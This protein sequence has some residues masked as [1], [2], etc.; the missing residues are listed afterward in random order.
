MSTDDLTLKLR[1]NMGYLL[2]NRGGITCSGGEPLVQAPFVRDLFRQT[3]AL[4]LTTC[5]DTSGMGQKDH[6][7]EVLAETDYVMLCTKSL[8]PD[9]HKAISGASIRHLLTFVDALDKAKVPFRVR[10][11]LIPEGPLCT[12]TP[13]EL[14]RVLDFVNAREHCIG[15][16]LLPYHKLG[17]HKWSAL[18]WEYPMMSMKSPS[19]EYLMPV[20][21]TLRGG[22]SEG[23]TLI[24]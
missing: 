22:L 3:R 2:P 24:L 18:G 16:E 4:G 23:K 1:K 17:V 6:Y 10:H 19:K 21:D 14:R 8:D 11:V 9:L 7:A 13:A 5:L 20:L 12:G 15:I